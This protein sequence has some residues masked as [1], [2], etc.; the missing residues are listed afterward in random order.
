MAPAPAPGLRPRR[1]RP[2]PRPPGAT[3]AARISRRSRRRVRA[4]LAEDEVVEREPRSGTTPARRPSHRRRR[5]LEVG[6]DASLGGRAA[7]VAS[8]AASCVASCVVAQARRVPPVAARAA[9]A[10]AA[11]HPRRRVPPRRADDPGLRVTLYTGAV[12][13]RQP[14]ARSRRWKRSHELVVRGP[15]RA[16]RRR[17]LAHHVLELAVHLPGELAV[18]PA[19]GSAAAV[20][21]E[22]SAAAAVKVSAARAS[23]HRDHLVDV[24]VHALDHALHGAAA[25]ALDPTVT[26]VPVRAGKRRVGVGRL[27]I[28]GAIGRGA[29]T[30]ELK[31]RAMRIFAREASGGR[32]GSGCGRTGS[33]CTA[34]SRAYRRRMSPRRRT[35]CPRTLRRGFQDAHREA[36]HRWTA[37]DRIWRRTCE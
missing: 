31:F 22:A 6:E 16:S 10:A 11:V 3:G 35:G 2:R 4:L 15:L 33:R 37:P 32:G 19:V 8:A 13:E 29:W 27:A 34:A 24:G 20:W 12:A 26:H 28:S 5:G 1:P 14:P 25:R 7:G 36:V 18:E 21:D 9:A 23:S 30:G 17:G